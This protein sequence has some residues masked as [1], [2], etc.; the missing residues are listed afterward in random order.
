MEVSSVSLS[1]VT[2]SMH[3]QA[4]AIDVPSRAR[5]NLPPNGI[6]LDSNA[7]SAR[8]MASLESFYSLP[9]DK[10]METFESAQQRTK[11]QDLVYS[12]QYPW[13]RV[14]SA[15]G[16]SR[17]AGSVQLLS[18]SASVPLHPTRLAVASTCFTPHVAAVSPSFKLGGVG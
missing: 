11:I 1:R 9:V 10:A 12:R 6:A 4:S 3:V 16:I 5:I 7:R 8:G 14:Y 17:P 2:R 18:L 15:Y 13:Q